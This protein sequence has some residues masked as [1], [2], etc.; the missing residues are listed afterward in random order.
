MEEKRVFFSISQLKIM[1]AKHVLAE[2]GIPAVSIDKMDSAHAL[3]FGGSI[4]LYV[5]QS[6]AAEARRILI[7]EEILEAS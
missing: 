1:T 6:R 7:Q 4:E 3:P 2:A 5:D